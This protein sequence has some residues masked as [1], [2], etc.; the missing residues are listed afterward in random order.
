MNSQKCSVQEGVRMMVTSSM[1][2]QPKAQ[3]ILNPFANVQKAIVVTQN[4][5]GNECN[6]LKD[7]GLIS[8]Q[9]STKSGIFP[10]SC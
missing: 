8:K 2:G 1:L 6:G 9:P 10:H 7:E 3:A 4:T 5:I